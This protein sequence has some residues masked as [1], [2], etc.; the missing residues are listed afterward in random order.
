VKPTTLRASPGTSACGAA[1]RTG[2]TVADDWAGHQRRLSVARGKVLALPD[3]KVH[4]PDDHGATPV[5]VLEGRLDCRKC[6][7][8]KRTG[9]GV[10][11]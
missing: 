11:E 3:A 5:H 4:R 10:L 6:R 8:A 2:A 9:R 7:R 1:T